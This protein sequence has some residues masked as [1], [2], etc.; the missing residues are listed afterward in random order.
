[1][2]LSIMSSILSFCWLVFLRIVWFLVFIGVIFYYIRILVY[3]FGGYIDKDH[4]T[5][6]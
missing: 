6:I 4:W 1:M 2:L 3:I 5:P